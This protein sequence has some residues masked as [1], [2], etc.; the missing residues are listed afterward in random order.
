MVAKQSIESATASCKTATSIAA[1]CSLVKDWVKFLWQC[2][3][4]LGDGIGKL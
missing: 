4:W 1:I 3:L 2:L